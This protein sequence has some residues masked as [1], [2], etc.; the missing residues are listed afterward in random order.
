MKGG[1]RKFFLNKFLSTGL[2]SRAFKPHLINC[3]FEFKDYR[4]LNCLLHYYYN[5]IKC[6]N[7]IVS[8]IKNKVGFYQFEIELFQE[9][10]TFCFSSSLLLCL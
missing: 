9:S 7:H 3:R 1:G 10:S 6:D 2:C 5:D 8:E 4:W